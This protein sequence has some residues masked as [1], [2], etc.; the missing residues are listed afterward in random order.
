LQTVMNSTSSNCGRSDSA[1][2]PRPSPPDDA[3]A[4]SNAAAAMTSANKSLF[5]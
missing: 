2:G 5:I 3:P 4:A 1:V